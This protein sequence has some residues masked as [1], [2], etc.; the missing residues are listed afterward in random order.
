MA[1]GIPSRM[2][3]SRQPNLS[4]RMTGEMPSSSKR[5]NGLWSPSGIRGNFLIF[6]T[7]LR[8]ILCHSKKNPDAPVPAKKTEPSPQKIEQEGYRL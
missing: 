4:P 6:E 5:I 3:A 2:C 1:P 8:R 7:N